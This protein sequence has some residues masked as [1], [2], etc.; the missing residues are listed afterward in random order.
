MASAQFPKVVLSLEKLALVTLPCSPLSYYSD[1]STIL[2]DS[3]TTY[4]H[5]IPH[6]SLQNRD[7]AFFANGD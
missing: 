7:L 3:F 6:M 1:E 4:L 5:C 2:H